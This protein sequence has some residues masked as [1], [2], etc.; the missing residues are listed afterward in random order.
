MDLIIRA[1]I[2]EDSSLIVRHLFENSL[3]LVASPEYLAL[4]GESKSRW[5]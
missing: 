1:R 3:L 2:L 5:G 4:H